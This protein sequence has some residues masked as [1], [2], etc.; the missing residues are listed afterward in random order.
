MDRG[1]QPDIRF[2]RAKDEH[3]LCNPP[4]NVVSP[5]PRRSPSRGSLSACSLLSPFPT[6][7][8]RESAPVTRERIRHRKSPARAGL[9][10]QGVG[11]VSPTRSHCPD[12]DVGIRTVPRSVLRRG[13]GTPSRHAGPCGPAFGAGG[14]ARCRE[15]CDRE[16]AVLTFSM[17]VS[18]AIILAALL[19]SACSGSSRVE[20]VVPAWANTGSASQHVAR[21]PPPDANSKPV[22]EPQP[23]AQPA[24]PQPAAQPVVRAPAATH[25]PAEE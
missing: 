11:I 17:H 7:G 16:S 3:T 22:A 20:H 12:E 18:L 15:R 5:E 4:V 2:C 9:S 10:K 21:K 13:S 19:L 1:I 6:K 14:S 24:V 8:R 25:G 23:T